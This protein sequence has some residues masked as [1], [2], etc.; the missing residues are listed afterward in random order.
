MKPLKPE[1]TLFDD[2]EIKEAFED[3]KKAIQESDG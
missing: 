3:A 2:E 1:Q